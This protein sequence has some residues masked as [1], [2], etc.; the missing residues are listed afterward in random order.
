M[1]ADWTETH[2]NYVMAWSCCGCY[3]K[4]AEVTRTSKLHWK[5]DGSIV[6]IGKSEKSVGISGHTWKKSIKV[7]VVEHGFRNINVPRI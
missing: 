4:H 7:E 6:I 1:T 2:N 5:N 3:I